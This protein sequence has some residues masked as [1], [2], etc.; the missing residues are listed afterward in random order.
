MLDGVAVDVRTYPPG[1]AAAAYRTA[2]KVAAVP[3]AG[4][5]ACGNGAA[6]ERAWSEAAAPDVAV[7][8]YR[9]AIERGHAAMW[10]THGDRL[11]HAV[12]G[13]G[14]LAALFAWWRTHPVV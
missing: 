5:P 11:T 14:D 12:A 4:P 10:W 9:C 3:H 13:D 8:R 1:T 7:G 6:D 2:T